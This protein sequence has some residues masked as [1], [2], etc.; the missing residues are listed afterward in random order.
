MSYIGSDGVLR[1]QPDS[2]SRWSLR[3]DKLWGHFAHLGNMGKR[4]A[5]ET[6]QLPDDG[7]NDHAP[8]FYALHMWNAYAAA[9][10][11]GPRRP[12]PP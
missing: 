1:L 2:M 8:L 9:A 12:H 4:L 10:P 6:V 5:E 11:D 3:R 7:F